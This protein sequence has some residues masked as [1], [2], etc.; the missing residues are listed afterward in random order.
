MRLMSRHHQ[1]A[2]LAVMLVVA[3]A[4]G[5]GSQSANQSFT[6]RFDVD[7]TDLVSTGRNPFFILEPGYTLTLEGGA[8]RLVITVLNETKTVDGVDTRIV[9]ERE[10]DKGQP[11]EVSRNYFAISKRTNAVFYFGE[12]VDMYKNGKVTGHEGA[13]L[14]GVNGAK[15]GLAMPGLPLMRA[16]YYQEIAP[17][18][19]M[20][21]AEI[22]AMSES[23]KTVAGAFTN[24]LKIEETT[25]LE[26]GAKE[27]KLYA[28]GVGLIQDGELKLVKYSR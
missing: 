12:D 11:V 27:A 28:P 9:E 4:V 14:S 13:W 8:V 18:V 6:S 16:R 25:P 24:V 19:A 21:R 20:G 26:P 7:R 22:V 1:F 17:K 10:T 5:L 23:L 3:A 15:F 2:L